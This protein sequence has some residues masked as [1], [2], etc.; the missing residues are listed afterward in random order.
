MPGHRG[1]ELLV[2]LPP[3]RRCLDNARRIGRSAHDF[4]Q[5][6]GAEKV[7]LTRATK[8][9]GVPSVPSRWLLRLQT[10]LAK[11]GCAESLEPDLPWLSW[12][13]QRDDGISLPRI[14]RRYDQPGLSGYTLDTTGG[15]N[16]ARPNRPL[17]QQQQQTNNPPGFRVQPG[18]SGYRRPD[19]G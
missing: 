17:Q 5:V 4:A 7:Y 10:V 14:S 1:T 19:G 9:D 3:F 12:A 6:L 18:N 13:G 16:L 11:L 2:G 15:Y 8:I